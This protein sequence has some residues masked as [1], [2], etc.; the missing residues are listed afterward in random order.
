MRCRPYRSSH[1]L[2]TPRLIYAARTRNAR[3]LRSARAI[4]S[5]PQN[6]SN[7]VI[8]SYTSGSGSVNY[9]AIDSAT[10]LPLLQTIAFW[11]LKNVAMGTDPFAISATASSGLPVTFNST[12]PGVCTVAGA[13][14][15]VAAVDRTERSG[16]RWTEPMAEAIV[17]LRAIYLAGDFDPYWQ[18]HI[19]QDQRRLYPT[20]C[21]VVPK[22]WP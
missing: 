9:T 5:A 8:L 18:F 21:G 3:D 2:R 22:C 16:M 13:T 19:E 4:G 12:T 17:Q 15:T 10:V 7:R 11:P 1:S 14:V 6:V 20:G